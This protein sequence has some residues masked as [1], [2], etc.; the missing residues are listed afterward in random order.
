M[1]EFYFAISIVF[2]FI[3]VG[4]YRLCLFPKWLFS[5]AKL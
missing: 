2:H 3:R 5:Y 4:V 1:G